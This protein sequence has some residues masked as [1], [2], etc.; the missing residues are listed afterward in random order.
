MAEK[1]RI[2]SWI[3]NIINSCEHPSH[4]EPCEVLITF[5][6]KKGAEAYLIKSLK[7][8]LKLKVLIIQEKAKNE[9]IATTE[10]EV[11]N[12]F[13]SGNYTMKQISEKLNIKLL[14]CQEIINRKIK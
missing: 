14:K 6:E 13:Q 8:S 5:Y 10:E 12:M 11:W 9:K 3:G 4:I 7:E 2:H 1:D